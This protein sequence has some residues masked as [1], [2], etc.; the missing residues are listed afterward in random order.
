MGVWGCAPQNS[1]LSL[2]ANVYG[3]ITGSA[4]ANANVANY[5]RK[6]YKGLE[7]GVN[8]MYTNKVAG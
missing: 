8:I 2:N 1:C 4:R 7:L 5:A 6:L 3:Q